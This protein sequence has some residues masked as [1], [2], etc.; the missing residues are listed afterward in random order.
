MRR[1]EN[2]KEKKKTG[3]SD[4]QR[5]RVVNAGPARI[6]LEIITIIENKGDDN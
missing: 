3:V 4:F 5:F 1:S 6:S 2:A